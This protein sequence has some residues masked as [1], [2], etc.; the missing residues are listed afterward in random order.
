LLADTRPGATEKQ[1]RNSAGKASL[2]EIIHFLFGADCNPDSLFR[3]AALVE[4]SFSGTLLIGGERF[5]I[6]RSG[7]APSEIFVLEGGHERP[8]LPLKTDRSTGRPFISNTNWCVFLGHALFGMPSD[9][10][11]S[12]FDESFTPSFR[13]IFSYFARRRNSGAFLRPERR[14]E[15]QQ[16]WDWQVN[17]SFLLGLD[18]LIPFEFQKLRTRERTLEELKKAAKGGALGPMVGTVAELRPQVTVAETKARRLRDQLANFEVLDSYRDL[19]RRAARAKTEMQ[20]LGRAA[21]GLQETLD[22]LERALAAESPPDRADL[23]RM[24]VS[25]ITINDVFGP[26]SDRI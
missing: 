26:V 14:A 22:H 21:V 16:R 23:Q 6:E 8:E 19:S 20:S 7:L 9:L 4:H 24:Y 2:L 3:K 17:L 10:E 25:L 5:K 13:S 11:G 12:V 15:Q 18:W 1:T